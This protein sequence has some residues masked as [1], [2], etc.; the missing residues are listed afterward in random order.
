MI[1]ELLAIWQADAAFPSGAFAFSNGLEGL[2]ALEG[3]MDA[4]RLEAVIEGTLRRRWASFDRIA[5]LKAYDAA[6]DLDAVAAIDREVEASTL[7]EPFRSGSRRNGA[8]LIAAHVRLGTPGAGEW[9]ARVRSGAALGH[10]AVAQ[11]I[12]WR[13]AGLSAKGATLASGYMTISGFTTSAV[14]L[15]LVGAVAAQSIVRDML[16][17]V[18]E[19]AETGPPAQLESFAPLLDIAAARH[20]RGELRLFSN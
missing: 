13:G 19:L 18:A 20:A 14:R 8:S 4:P 3:G 11:G 5:M 2:S 6:G 17:V 15:G 9:Q 1:G 10:L 12:V 16:P 7:S